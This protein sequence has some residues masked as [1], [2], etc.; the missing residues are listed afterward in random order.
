MREREREFGFLLL[1]ICFLNVG[2]GKKERA[3]NPE[4]NFRDIFW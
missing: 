1:N 3:E 2:D 4:H